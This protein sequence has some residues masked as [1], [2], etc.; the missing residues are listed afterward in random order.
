MHDPSKGDFFDSLGFVNPKKRPR[1]EEE[2][3]AREKEAER[4]R[5]ERELN[6]EMKGNGEEPLLNSQS[7]GGKDDSC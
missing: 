6:P 4:I 3:E 1:K 2:R 7:T 5:S